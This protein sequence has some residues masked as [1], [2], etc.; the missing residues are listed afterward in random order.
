MHVCWGAGEGPHN[1][2]VPLHDIVDI[3]LKGRLNALSIVRANGRHEH[4]WKE[5]WGK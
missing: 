2:D 4:E 3:L 1:H 5:L